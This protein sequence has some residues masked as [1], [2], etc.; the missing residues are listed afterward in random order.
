MSSNF[1]ESENPRLPATPAPDPHKKESREIIEP[2][3]D[4]DEK[5][6]DLDDILQPI[7]ED[8]TNSSRD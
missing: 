7:T 8:D 2:A 3:I 1:E 6:S 5:I 4:C